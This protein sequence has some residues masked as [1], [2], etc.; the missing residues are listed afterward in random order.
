MIKRLVSFMALGGL[1]ASA[2]WAQESEAL[3]KTQNGVSVSLSL[4]KPSGVHDFFEARGFA[5]NTLDQFKG[6]CFL[7]VVVRN[8]SGEV[9][10]LIPSRWRITGEG[11]QPLTRVAREDWEAAWEKALVPKAHRATFGWT[12]LPESRDLQPHE[13][14]GGNL[15]FLTLKCT[16]L[17]FTLEAVFPTQPD[18]KGKELVFRFE[19]L[20]CP[21]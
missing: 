20:S 15:T 2:P 14:V 5:P 16:P 19:N 4:R 3:R 10:W 18:Q 8:L 17:R 13:P 6:V 21:P 9:T 7:G 12:L 1:L 11:G